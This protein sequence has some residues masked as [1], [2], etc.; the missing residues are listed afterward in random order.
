MAGGEGVE[1]AVELL[2][3]G[4]VRFEG[5]RVPTE[6]FLLEMR[7]RVRAAEGE[8]RRMPA[9]HVHADPRAA[10][11]PVDGLLRQLRTAGVRYVVLE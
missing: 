8:A 11:A 6:T 2:G 5:R 3:G 9:V 7:A 1:T 10:L 4:F